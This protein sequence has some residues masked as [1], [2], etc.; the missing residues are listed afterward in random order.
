MSKFLCN[1]YCQHFFL[2]G[3]RS[4]PAALAALLTLNTG[5][6]YS[7]PVIVQYKVA[8]WKQF[9]KTTTSYDWLLDLS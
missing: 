9:K 1:N 4:P 8:N 6:F 3:G 2:A 5:L 7:L